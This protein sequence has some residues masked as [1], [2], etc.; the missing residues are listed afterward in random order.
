MPTSESTRRN[1]RAGEPKFSQRPGYEPIPGYKLIEPLGAGGFS[2]VWRVEAP[3][4]LQKAAKFVRGLIS[5]KGA[6]GN[7]GRE[8]KVLTKLREVR[9]PYV[10]SLER[11]DIVNDQLIIIME[12]ADRDLA[13]LL[14]TRQGEGFAGIPR[15]ELLRYMEEAAEALDLVNAEFGIQ[16]LDIKPA[17]LFDVRGHIK[18]ADFGLAKM[19]EGERA[20]MSGGITPIYAAPESFDGW[21][22]RNTDQYSLAIVYQEMLSGR[23][24]FIGPS[25]MQLMFQH[26]TAEPDVSSL[27]ED[28]RPIIRRALEKNPEKRWGSCSEFVRELMKVEAGNWSPMATVNIKASGTHPT[29]ADSNPPASGSRA[30]RTSSPRHSNFSTGEDFDGQRLIRPT[31]V[32]GIGPGGMHVADAFE[33]QLQR[34]IS[35]TAGLPAPILIALAGSSDIDSDDSRLIALSTKSVK[36]YRDNWSEL[37]AVCH[38]ESDWLPDDGQ[39]HELQRRR[40]ARLAWRERLPETEVLFGQRLQVL[41]HWCEQLGENDPLIII[42]IDMAGAGEDAFV[43]D[44]LPTL[45][46]LLEGC[47]LIRATINLLLLTAGSGDSARLAGQ[48][49][50]GRELLA[51]Q[52]SAVA[53]FDRIL[54]IPR[55]A[56]GLW[57][58]TAVQLC[59]DSACPG[60]EII[61]SLPVQ[62]RAVTV[63]SAATLEFPRDELVRITSQ[64]A[65]QSLFTH[66]QRSLSTPEIE[67]MKSVCSKWWQESGFAGDVFVDRFRRVGLSLVGAIVEEQLK[68]FQKRW[69]TANTKEW[70]DDNARWQSE[71]G[72][73]A[74]AVGDRTQSNW[75]RKLSDLANE[76]RSKTSQVMDEMLARSAGIP[77]PR[78]AHVQQC[79]DFVR[80]QLVQ[81]RDRL[82][83]RGNVCSNKH[84]QS[85]DELLE[86]LRKMRKSS[87]SG[88]TSKSFLWFGSREKDQAAD[89]KLSE[90]KEFLAAWAKQIQCWLDADIVRQVEELVKSLLDRWTRHAN[91][92]AQVRGD[93]DRLL[94]SLKESI[95]RKPFIT[96]NQVFIFPDES[97]TFLEVVEREAKRIRGQ[98]LLSID[99]DVASILAARAGN[100]WSALAT[101]LAN[102]KPA[103][104]LTGSLIRAVE[105]VVQRLLPSHTTLDILLDLQ[106]KN[107]PMVKELLQTAH[108]RSAW[109]RP[110]DA[111][112]PTWVVEV[113]AVPPADQATRLAAWIPEA[114]GGSPVLRMTTR[115]GIR[116][117]RF[118][119]FS[120]S[121]HPF[122]FQEKGLIDQAAGFLNEHPVLSVS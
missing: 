1:S 115:P 14:R 10:L 58:T 97:K 120:C 96:S 17:N 95:D 67:R 116:L 8:L 4:G 34:R 28:D 36:E 71:L 57:I 68:E 62:R 41:K 85:I 81:E 69:S 60:A 30:V 82:V 43:T 121:E 2:E 77:G 35:N 105:T 38:V 88:E 98:A 73:S 114:T 107:A 20:K 93:L 21:V 15:T 26:S 40:L 101:C 13:D 87:P 31:L 22:S 74:E 75:T 27:P 46:R 117:Y 50:L 99:R 119:N 42:A 112:E 100:V 109:R 16:H 55:D 110:A 79:V 25:P 47:G 91:A 44:L 66:W 113:V 29:P 7:V 52:E 65:S 106:S 53:A 3:G 64:H 5:S 90:N 39:P 49:S 103:K 6:H 37:S 59:L 102:A 23:R 72:L 33:Q 18:V 70:G 83:E 86:V 78:L 11:V 89:S 56:D 24:P 12:L 9:H 122:P 51:L 54:A 32:F 45:R 84:Q 80:L 111:A 92:L 108:E 19:F 94:G 118:Y 76:I 61:E 104:A 48:L 63:V